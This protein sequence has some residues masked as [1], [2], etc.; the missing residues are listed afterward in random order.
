M[1][2]IKLTPA[3]QT[4]AIDGASRSMALRSGAGCGKTFVLARRYM[5]LL[6]GSDPDDWPL[7]R[8]VALTFTDKAAIE[9]SQRVR[10]MLV[11]QARQ[12]DGPKRAQL[13]RWID[14]LPEARISTIHSFCAS[15]LRA[16]A[17]EAGVDPSFA[18]SADDLLVTQLLAE[19][20]DAAVLAAAE[21]S[22]AKLTF[23]LQHLPYPAVIELLTRL[24]SNRQLL[25]SESYRDPES[26]IAGWNELLGRQREAAWRRLEADSELSGLASSVTDE[27]CGEPSDKLLAKREELMPAVNAIIADPEARTAE[28]F[29]FACGYPIGGAGTKAAWGSKENAMAIRRRIKRIKEILEGYRLYAETLNEMDKRSAE[30]LVALTSLADD[31]GR[32]YAASKRARG[33]LDFNDLIAGA[34]G[35]IRSN[36][37]VRRQLADGIDQLLIDECQDT[38]A[39]QLQMLADLIA[40]DD[41]SRQAFV[42][43]DAK[44]SIYRFRGADVAEFDNT[45]LRLGRGQN[46]SLDLSF[47]THAAGVAFVN[48]LFAPLMGDRYDEITAHRTE[49]PP[50]E[51]VEILLADRDTPIVSAEDASA[52][53]AELTAQRISEMISNREKLV[54]DD[55]AGDWR[56]V[57]PRDVAIL[58]SRMTH[59]LEYERQL[60]KHNVPY[61]VVA[62]TGFF[63][64]QEVFDVLNALRVIDNPL[65]DIA[66][67]GVLRSSLVALDDNALMHITESLQGGP[68]LAKLASADQSDLRDRLAPDQFDAMQFAVAL[69]RRLAGRKNAVAIDELLAQL[70]DETGY[71]AVLSAQFGAKRL[72]GNIRQL[73][74][75]AAAADRDGMSLRDFITRTD[76][77]ILSESRYE[78]AVVAGEND[79]VVKLM[80]IHKSKGL[81]FGV[82]VMPDLNAGRR[83]FVGRLLHRGADWGWTL[84]VKPDPDE[85]TEN[86]DDAGPQSFRLA[87]R[88]ENEDLDAEDIRK[89]Y[90][91]ITRHRDHLVLIGA[92]HR[93]KKD[94]SISSSTSMLARIDSVT[95]FVDAI[96]ADAETIAYGGGQFKA[97]VA[98]VLPDPPRP[99]SG[100]ETPGRQAIERAARASDLAAEM[101]AAGSQA[102]PPPLIGPL[103][104]SIG[105]V[106]TAVTALSEFA[107]CPMLYRWR[108]E[109]AAP[110]QVISSDRPG[111]GASLDAMTLGTLYHRCMELLNFADP[112]P[113]EKLIAQA[114]WEMDLDDAVNH[115]ALSA[116]L[117]DMISRFAK[118]DLWRSLAS[119]KQIYREL[120]FVL[121]AGQL[122]LRGQ[123]DLLYCDD[124]GDWHVVDYKSDRVSGDDQIAERAKNYELQMLAYSIAAQRHLDQPVA[125]ASLYFLRPAK[126]HAFTADPAALQDARNRLAGLTEQLITAR[127]S[128]KFDRIESP[129]C[130]YCPYST[131]CGH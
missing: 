64:Q 7:R 35:L 94:D 105:S 21:A 117:D 46:E 125:D 5:E 101:L 109:L 44:Q 15:L 73:T 91:A 68:Y 29:A 32:R 129:R 99:Q 70:L 111:G 19:A 127:R 118:H 76:Q 43:G 122:T 60:Q 28:N 54:W 61:Y 114:V 42:V 47:R 55:D 24:I 86:T 81:E 131:L 107:H 77:L 120:D 84:N 27:P 97:R 13:R 59:S 82:V 126:Q 128:D 18:V 85:E 83:G 110:E 108:Y 20:C 3:Q 71:L 63:K 17:V 34:S 103:P 8:L 41:N 80:T 116:E 66:L 25:D 1:S 4:A 49:T 52:A 88:A 79:N 78:Q 57:Q 50:G 93:Y 65:D 102:P 112:Q 6:T 48:H 67:F 53:Q 72:A 30:A 9:M 2:E 16:H 14:E 62:G 11:E 98:C 100:A 130:N 90:V 58:L 40:G 39:F 51:S 37:D 121:T 124:R 26:V 104:A 56:P 113:N 106:E 33:L 45:C 123:I 119:A 31:A 36:P 12:T 95:N 23:L 38:D 89:L 69:L 96:D 92:N 75:R 87:S 115:A 74:E 22:D 10:K